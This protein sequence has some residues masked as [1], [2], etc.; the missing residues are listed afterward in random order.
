MRGEK[1]VCYKDRR[2][3]KDEG[4][5]KK[6]REFD[7]WITTSRGKVSLGHKQPSCGSV[8]TSLALSQSGL[9]RGVNRFKHFLLPAGMDAGWGRP[10]HGRAC[11][12]PVRQRAPCVPNA[13]GGLRQQL[14]SQFNYSV[15]L[16]KYK[17][18]LN[19]TADETISS[20]YT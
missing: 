8:E 20:G 2:D 12:A 5:I 9:G 15:D 6:P 19:L 14:D 10:R 13:A 17:K 7:R 3:T 18:K 1:K 4:G 11:S 16:A